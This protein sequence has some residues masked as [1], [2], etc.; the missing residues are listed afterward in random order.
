MHD[1]MTHP[2]VRLDMQKCV[3][4]SEAP[5][6]TEENSNSYLQLTTILAEAHTL[7]LAVLHSVDEL[8]VPPLVALGQLVVTALDR[9]CYSSAARWKLKGLLRL[10]HGLC[11]AVARRRRVELSSIGHISR[12]DGQRANQSC[13]SC[14]WQLLGKL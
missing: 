4:C 6:C 9:G 2:I 8:A 12:C 5:D 3:C 13:K 1:L 14:S 10:L 11:G 7:N